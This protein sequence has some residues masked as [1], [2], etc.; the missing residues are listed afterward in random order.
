MAELTIEQVRAQDRLDC[1]AAISRGEIICHTSGR[2]GRWFTNRRTGWAASQVPSL[3]DEGLAKV[4]GGGRVRLTRA[5]RAALATTTD[6]EA[7][8]D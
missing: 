6:V 8:R 1:L 2:G 7:D 5:G 4:T 3:V